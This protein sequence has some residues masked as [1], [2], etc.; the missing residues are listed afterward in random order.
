MDIATMAY[1]LEARSPLLDHELMSWAATIPDSQKMAG[2]ETKQLMKRA[3]EPYLPN[4]I[5]YRPKMGFG[6]PIDRWLKNELKEIARDCVDSPRAR[7]R[8]IF[9]PSY[10]AQLLE[11]HCDGTRQHHPRLWAMIMLELWYRTWIDNPDPVASGSAKEHPAELV[12]V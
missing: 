8:G 7:Q 4:E 1:G 11:Q 10:G 6:V 12:R 3:L 9:R 2:G 5:R